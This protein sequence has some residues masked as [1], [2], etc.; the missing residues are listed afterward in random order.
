MI[1]FE[2]IGVGFAGSLVL[3]F[4]AKVVMARLLQRDNDFYHD[5]F[6]RGGEADD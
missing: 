1:L 2:Y 5:E 6:D 4:L 3:I